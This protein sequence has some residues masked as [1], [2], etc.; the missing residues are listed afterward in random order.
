MLYV[1]K[2]LS[3]R[4]RVNKIGEIEYLIQKITTRSG[5]SFL[6]AVPYSPP[7]GENL[8]DFFEALQE[9]A[10]SVNNII[11]T[12]DINA[13]IERNNRLTSAFRATFLEN[14]LHLVNSGPSYYRVD[15]PSWLDIFLVDDLQKVVSC[16]SSGQSYI[17]GDDYLCIAYN[18]PGAPCIHTL[19]FRDYKTI[20]PSCFQRDIVDSL[21]RA[22]D[23]LFNE[24][25]DAS[26][27]SFLSNMAT[28]LNKHLP[29]KTY[30]SKRPPKSYI[31]HELKMLMKHR[32]YLYA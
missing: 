22:N 30:T 14:K 7:L 19:Q 31:S 28:V 25:I 6:V 27:D 8:D 18:L 11:V 16:Q 2:F 26:F 12:G 24:G 32:D 3:F 10:R 29:I 1:H 20:N 9:V 17:S 15:P 23:L 4:K 5:A 13:H 21:Q